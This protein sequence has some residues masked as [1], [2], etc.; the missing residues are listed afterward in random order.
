MQSCCTFQELGYLACSDTELTVKLWTLLHTLVELWTEKW[1]ITSPLPQFIYNNG[2]QT[3]WPGSIPG[4]GTGILFFV[5]KFRR[6]T[7]PEGTHLQ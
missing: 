6:V 7:G 5:N 1:P 2:L 3:G 4:R